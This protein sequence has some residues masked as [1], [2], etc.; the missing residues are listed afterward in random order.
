MFGE[1][2]SLEGTACYTA[3]IFGGRPEWHAHR[4]SSNDASSYL[5]KPDSCEKSSVDYQASLR[6]ALVGLLG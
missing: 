3:S 1:C 4:L 2:F 5:S 6:L